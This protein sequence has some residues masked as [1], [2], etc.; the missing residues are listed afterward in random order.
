MDIRSSF[1][2]SRVLPATNDVEHSA[3]TNKTGED[4][5]IATTETSP[6]NEH[7]DKRTS[8]IPLKMKLFAILLVTATGFGSHWSSGVTGAMKSTLKKVHFVS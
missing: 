3:S 8:A 4:V 2:C 6:D 5:V 7:D 1:E